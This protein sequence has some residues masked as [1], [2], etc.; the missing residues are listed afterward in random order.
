MLFRRCSW[1]LILIL[2]VT[3]CA[4]QRIIEELGFIESVGYDPYESE[5]EG[6]E[7]L[8]YLVTITMPQ[9]LEAGLEETRSRP[10]R[11]SG[12]VGSARRQNP[13]PVGW[14]DG[15]HIRVPCVFAG[16]LWCVPDARPA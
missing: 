1:F 8:Q 2:V 10:V 6:E 3:G 13:F 11:R 14:S 5:E 15:G 4:E 9:F 12:A 16:P 7:D